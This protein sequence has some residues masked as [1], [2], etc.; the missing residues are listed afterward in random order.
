MT[1]R[2]HETVA[3]AKGI[4][5]DKYLELFTEGLKE[6]DEVIEML[7]KQMADRQIPEPVYA[8]DS[9]PGS[10]VHDSDSMVP[11]MGND[12]NNTEN[13]RACRRC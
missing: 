7:K 6:L 12:F 3:K 2:M 1:K 5:E 8:R 9:S 10:D 4:V 11:C 13:E